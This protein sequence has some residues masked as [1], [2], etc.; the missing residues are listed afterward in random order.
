[1][2]LWRILRRALALLLLL[3]LRPRRAIAFGVA[4]GLVG[5]YLVANARVIALPGGRTL[6]DLLG[7]LPAAPG[8]VAVRSEVRYETVPAVED[9]LKG[10]TQFD[11]RLMWNAL[12]EEAILSLRSRGATLEALQ[13]SLDEQRRRGVRYEDITFIGSFALQDGRRYL[14]YVLS[15]RGFS[16]GRD[17]LDQIYYVFTVDRNGKIVNIE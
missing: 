2:G 15:R 7:R 13:Q 6:A 3:V 17:D 8:A 11:A 16:G 12:S 5:W 9:Y 10:L 1:M 14:F 4:V